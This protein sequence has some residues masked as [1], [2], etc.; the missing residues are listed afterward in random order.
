VNEARVT[1]FA[2]IDSEAVGSHRW[3]P[4]LRDVDGNYAGLEVWFGTKTEC[5]AWMREQG[6]SLDEQEAAE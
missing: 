3:Q 2:G 6:F 5:V 4:T 1:W